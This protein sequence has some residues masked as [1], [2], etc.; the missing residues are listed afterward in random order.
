[1]WLLV[2]LGNPEPRYAAHRHNVGFMALDAIA[3]RH[4]FGAW[5]SVKFEAAAAEG[6]LGEGGGDDARVLAFKPM[7]Y[8]NE[9]GRA[10]GPMM[11]WLKL[12]PERVIVVH[13]DLD[14]APGKLR[15]K[16]GGGHGGHNGL[17]SLDAEIG[18]D[19]RRV[20]IGIGHPGHKELVLRH[21]LSD[22]ADDERGWLTALLD[23]IAKAAPL[24]TGTDEHAFANKVNRLLAP[25]AEPA[26]PKHAPP[27]E[28]AE[29]DA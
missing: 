8:M 16:R 10:V 25:P 19:Y 11:R 18:P 20:R 27:P 6:T 2:G 3:A 29:P 22:F 1:M 15:T 28:A 24:L 23:A 5:R 14:L 12:E 26:A 21:V 7:T 4:G 9:S 17:R 13:D